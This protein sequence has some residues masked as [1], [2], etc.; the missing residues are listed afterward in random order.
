MHPALAFVAYIAFLA[1]LGF[2]VFTLGGC[3]YQQ[4]YTR[5]Q[6]WHDQQV[7]QMQQGAVIS[8]CQRGLAC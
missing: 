2:T 6:A 1:I 4:P 3:V 5:L 7:M 8:N